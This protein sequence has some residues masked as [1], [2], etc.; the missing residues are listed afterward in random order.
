MTIKSI[1]KGRDKREKENNNDEYILR[2][3]RPRVQLELHRGEMAHSVRS[4]S[5]A[6]P[7]TQ[8][9]PAF[10][11]LLIQQ[12]QQQR[13]TTSNLPERAHLLVL[14]RGQKAAS[15]AAISSRRDPYRQ[16]LVFGGCRNGSRIA[17][18]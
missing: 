16:I 7:Q 4:A 2:S 12:Q 17:L 11:S 3:E 9:S 1:K 15:A 18:K 13:T 14:G 5:K 8:H 10:L 6:A